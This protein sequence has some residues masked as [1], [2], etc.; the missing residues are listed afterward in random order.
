MDCLTCSAKV[1]CEILNECEYLNGYNGEEPYKFSFLRCPICKDCIL[2]YSPFCMFEDETGS[3]SW[4]Y[5]R[6][7]RVWPKPDKTRDY[8]VPYEIWLDAVEADKC[9]NAGA[10][11]ASL[12]MI[13]KAL[14][15][16]CFHLGCKKNNLKSSI[17]ELYD[18][19]IIDDRLFEWSELLR[20][21]GNFAA[22]KLTIHSNIKKQDVEDI[23][24]F[25]YALLDYVF[26]LS[27]KYN[28][29][30]ERNKKKPV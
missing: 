15:T 14:E 25:L 22:H 23:Q 28:Q 1:D 10:Y 21:Y 29:F 24:D 17:K 9:K 18:K 4:D 19:K 7:E 8:S 27:S 20:K 12:I 3:T 26:V 13:R 16:T 11:N 5:T 6:P 30:L 2:A